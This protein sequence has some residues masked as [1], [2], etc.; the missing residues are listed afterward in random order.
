MFVTPTRNVG[1]EPVRLH[2]TPAI[3]T[4]REDSNNVHNLAEF[5]ANP[6]FGT[7]QRTLHRLGASVYLDVPTACRAPA[8][9]VGIQGVSPRRK[10]RA[11]QVL[12][13]PRVG[14]SHLGRM[15]DSS[16][17]AHLRGSTSTYGAGTGLLGAR[18]AVDAGKIVE[19]GTVMEV[20]DGPSCQFLPPYCQISASARARLEFAVL[21]GSL[22]TSIYSILYGFAY[23]Y[24]YWDGM[25]SRTCSKCLRIHITLV[26]TGVSLGAV[27][28]TWCARRFNRGDTPGMLTRLAGALHTLCTSKSTRPR[29]NR[30]S[31]KK[32][33]VPRHSEG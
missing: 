9:R 14:G 32:F 25:E 3:Y 4:A 22:P 18:S 20:H 12:S 28:S 6:S 13:S 21:V 29:A 30:H 16:M 11:H 10:R 2:S 19:L 31:H 27:L 8:S 7:A 5:E 15:E 23:V 1:T 26:A 17:R 24:S 33:F